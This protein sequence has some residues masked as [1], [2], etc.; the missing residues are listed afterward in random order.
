[1]RPSGGR[2]QRFCRSACRRKFHAAV[3][4]WGLDAVGTGALTIADIRNGSATTRALLLCGEEQTGRVRRG[5]VDLSF[6]VLPNVIED[7]GRLGWLVGARRVDDAVAAAVAEL[8][9]RGIALGL[10]PT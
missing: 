4:R 5:S 10:R 1:M 8:V 3:R 7:L 6:R 9:E 2:A